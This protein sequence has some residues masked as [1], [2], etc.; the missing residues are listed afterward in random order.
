VAKKRTDPAQSG[1]RKAISYALGQWDSLEVYL[2]D[3]T[4][5]IDNNLVENAIRPT[6]LEK[7]YDKS[8]IRQSLE[9]NNSH[10]YCASVG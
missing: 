3:G 2:K 4:I 6:A 9:E 5:E 10:L 1:L 7:K 8:G